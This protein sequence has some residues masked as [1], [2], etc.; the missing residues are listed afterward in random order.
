MTFDD[1]LHGVAENGLYRLKSRTTTAT[2]AERVAAVG[3][4]C[5]VLDGAAIDNKATFLA[6]A[7]RVLLFPAYVGENWDAFEEALNDMRWAD[8]PGYVLLI[9][10][11]ERF[12][13]T[14]PEEWA[15]ARSI[16]AD[17]ATQWAGQDRRFYVLLRI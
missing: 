1:L 14:A 8:A 9:E 13:A 17:A 7:G 2:L 4:R 6:E 10:H 3:W 5:F 12:A 16:F 15:I 11:H